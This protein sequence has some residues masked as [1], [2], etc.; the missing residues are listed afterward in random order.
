MVERRI[1]FV[2]IEIECK[3]Q[4]ILDIGSIKNDGSSFHKNSVTEFM[5]FLDGTQ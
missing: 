1:T 3:S 5:Q 2:D 4:K